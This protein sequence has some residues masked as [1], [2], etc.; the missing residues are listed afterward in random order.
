MKIKLALNKAYLVSEIKKEV[1][2]TLQ[3]Y[4]PYRRD[5][6]AIENVV[7]TAY[8]SARDDALAFMNQIDILL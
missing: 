7:V 1:F 4:A 6:E 2:D 3:T 8:E 5:I